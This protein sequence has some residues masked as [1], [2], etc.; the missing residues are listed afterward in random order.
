MKNFENWE[1]QDL[2]IEFGLEQVREMPLL[3]EWLQKT[4]TL[5]E[6]ETQLVE[7]LRNKLLDNA[8]FW[9]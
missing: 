5:T 6:Y 9:N 1:T 2:E 4:T 7:Y 3:E 8:D